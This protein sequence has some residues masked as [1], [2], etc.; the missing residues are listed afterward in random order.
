MRDI[1]R[2]PPDSL[3]IGIIGTIRSGEIDLVH[4]CTPNHLHAPFALKA[5]SAGLAVICEKPLAT[6]AAPR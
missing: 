6:D 1:S 3:R 2:E 4:I 5:L